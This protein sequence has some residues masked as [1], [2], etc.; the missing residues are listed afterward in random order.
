MS[1]ANA[2]RAE[3]P[4]TLVEE[5]T[6][7]KGSLSSK[8][9]IEVKGRVE[10]DLQAPSLTVS[11]KGAVHGKVK[12]DELFSE[13][14]IAGEFDAD[15][16][17]L[18]GVVK[19]N[20]VIRAK[21]LEV[22]LAPANGGRMQLVFGECAL[23]VGDAPTKEASVAKPTA[24][25]VE[26]VRVD[27]PAADKALADK[28]SAD[29]APAAEAKLDKSDKGDKPEKSEKKDKVERA[30]MPPPSAANGGL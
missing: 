23:E 24:A 25:T 27:K 30:S 10:G 29:R 8:C 15:V 16:V 14:E 6:Q 12:V 7:F 9:P 26:P 20:T 3:G 1:D 22:K 4:R 28:A 21:S 11:S 17:R 18:S 5:G 2:K 13:G 19:D